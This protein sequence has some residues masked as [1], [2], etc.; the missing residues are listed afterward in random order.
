MSFMDDLNDH[1]YQLL[2]DIILLL[3][4]VKR[5]NPASASVLNMDV[6]LKVSIEVMQ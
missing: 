1:H 6:I 3:L 2:P 4:K 5:V